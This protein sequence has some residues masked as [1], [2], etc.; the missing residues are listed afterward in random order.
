MSD[1]IDFDASGVLFDEVSMDELREKLIDRVIDYCNGE[2]TKA[3][4]LGFTELA[5]QRTAVFV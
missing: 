2:E 3:E 5:I 4:E 1:N